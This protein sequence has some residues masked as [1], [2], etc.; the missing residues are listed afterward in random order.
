[1]HEDEPVSKA[2]ANLASHVAR[3]IAIRNSGI[4]VPAENLV[5]IS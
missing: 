1:M 3:Q 4:S 5:A 2:F